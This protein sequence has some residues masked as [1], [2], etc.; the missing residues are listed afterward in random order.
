M[1]YHFA[2]FI[3]TR[4]KPGAKQRAGREPFQRLSTRHKTVKTVFRWVSSLHST[5][6]GC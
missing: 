2:H 4:L 3:N 6:A 5:Q 1:I